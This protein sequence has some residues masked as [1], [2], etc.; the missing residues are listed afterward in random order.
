L[1][2]FYFKHCCAILAIALLFQLILRYTC[3][4]D[5]HK[6]ISA[7]IGKLWTQLGPKVSG[8]NR[9]YGHGGLSLEV[10]IV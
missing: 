8:E 6:V 10:A 7:V 5:I 9:K 4:A 3:N 1:L 2:L